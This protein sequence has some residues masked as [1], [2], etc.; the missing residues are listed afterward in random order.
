MDLTHFSASER[1]FPAAL[2]AFVA[3]FHILAILSAL[4]LSSL[5]EKVDVDNKAPL[6]PIQTGTLRFLTCFMESLRTVSAN[7][8][9]NSTFGLPR[10]SGEA[11]PPPSCPCL[12]QVS[13]HLPSSPRGFVPAEPPGAPSLLR[14]LPGGRGLVLAPR[15][16]SATDLG[17]SRDSSTSLSE[18]A[19]VDWQKVNTHENLPSDARTSLSWPVRACHP[20]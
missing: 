17:P 6:M 10:L 8:G 7:Y 12:F 16:A 1:L 11:W 3:P 9:S 5:R 19:G 4:C 20:E 18:A 13:E 15:G 14:A 2:L